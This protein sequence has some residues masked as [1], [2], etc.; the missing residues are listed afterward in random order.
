MLLVKSE[1]ITTASGFGSL[2][3][4]G[5]RVGGLFDVDWGPFLGEV[6]LSK[7][8]LVGTC[9]FAHFEYFRFSSGI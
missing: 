6:L 1:W 7:G 5:S 2:V 9:S 3:R 4:E 8:R